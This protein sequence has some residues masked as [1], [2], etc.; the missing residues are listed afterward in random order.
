MIRRAGT[1]GRPIPL[2][3]SMCSALT[4]IGAAGGAGDGLL[5]GGVRLRQAGAS[6]TPLSWLIRL[7]REFGTV[8]RVEDGLLLGGDVGGEGLLGVVDRD[9]R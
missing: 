1:V 5:V 6:A 4:A 8:G 3:R 7:V 2:T 9:G